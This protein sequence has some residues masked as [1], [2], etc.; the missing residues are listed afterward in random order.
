M[1]KTP[2]QIIYH[3]SK[4]GNLNKLKTYLK[5]LELNM[6]KVYSKN[7]VKNGVKNVVNAAR[8]AEGFTSLMEASYKGHLEIVRELC[9]RGANVNAA[10]TDIGSTSLMCASEKGHLEV[11]RELCVRGANVNAAR[12]D[13]GVTSL[14][15][16]S[17]EG[18]LEIVRELCDHGANVNAAKTNDGSTSLILASY[19]GHLEIVRALLKAGAN[20][21]LKNKHG[22]TALSLADNRAIKNLIS[23]WSTIIPNPLS[24]VVNPV[25]KK[26]NGEDLPPFI[27]NGN[28]TKKRNHT[29]VLNPLRVAS[30]ANENAPTSNITKRNPLSVA[31]N[32]FVKT[33]SGEDLP[34]FIPPTMNPGMTSTSRPI[35]TKNP[36]S[37]GGTLRLKKRKRTLKT[38]KRTR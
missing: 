32:P 11:V 35:I 16:A 22:K 15:C 25:V 18:H 34:P 14:M 17:Q 26:S 8:T 9:D 23:T 19:N 20:L 36:L 24:S 1:F 21:R 38:R 7:G 31:F 6:A 33:S 2:E 13:N 27:P 28:N 10:R 4:T 30:N 5:K 12:T 37:F 29:K 3:A